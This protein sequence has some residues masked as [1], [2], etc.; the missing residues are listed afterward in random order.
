MRRAPAKTPHPRALVGAERLAFLEGIRGVLALYVA[1][2]HVFTMVDPSSVTGRPSVAP[3]WLQALAAP[4]SYGHVAVAMFIVVSGF[5]LQ[6]GLLQ[7]G[8]SGEVGTVGGFFRR[9]A[10]RILP[11]YYAC[12]LLSA[13]VAAG[14]TPRY[15]YPPFT[16][17]LPVDAWT[18]TSHVFLVHNLWPGWMLKINGV[19]WTIA[20]EAQLYLA[21][22]VLAALQARRGRGFTLLVGALFGLVLNELLVRLVPSGSFPSAT[23][24]RLW[25]AFL[26]AVGMAAAHLVFRPPLRGRRVEA[27]VGA[28]G[29]TGLLVG[30]VALATMKPYD[31]EASDVP[32]GIALA[33]L[34]ALGTMGG[35][36]LAIRLLGARPLAALGSFSY[37]LYL[38][39]H[40]VEQI[41]Y[42]L[43][44][45][46]LAGL[47]PTLAWLALLGIPAMLGAAWLFSL[48]FE[49]PFLRRAARF[50]RTRRTVPASLPLPGR[51]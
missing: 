49:R 35:G 50:P 3:P 44:P 36:G 42:A 23:Y 15:P 32:L 24:L 5:S 29:W 30:V 25:F 13:A 12:L 47:G 7:G 8:G 46:T 41:V 16:L 20:A 22:P 43:R 1:T 26:F 37:S 33:C 6:L 11:A 28:F 19:L 40:P 10:R 14:V 31:Y 18:F 2:G 38:V 39:H 27:W 9:R 17:Y 21:F 45:P 34:C 4:F 48:V 51:R